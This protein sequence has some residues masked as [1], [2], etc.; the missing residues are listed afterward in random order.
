M[1]KRLLAVLLLLFPG[2]ALAKPMVSQA[3]LSGTIDRARVELVL[4]GAPQFHV[5]YLANPYR[6][7][8]DMDALDW[9]AAPIS[10][11]AKDRLVTGLRYGVQKTGSSRLVLDLAA[12]ARIATARYHADKASAKTHLIIDLQAAS[13]ANFQQ[14]MNHNRPSPKTAET[15]DIEAAVNMTTA[16]GKPSTPAQPQKA[17]QQQAAAQRNVDQAG[18]DTTVDAKKQAYPEPLLTSLDS[19]LAHGQ[20]VPDPDEKPGFSSPDGYFVSYMHPPGALLGA[21]VTVGM[22]F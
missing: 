6:I 9:H 5:L 19:E 14:A 21:G 7:V 13:S 18:G 15:K 17:Q 10:G 22:Q 8:I 3:D 20:Q 2:S 4:T 16:A 12:P 1:M 11:G